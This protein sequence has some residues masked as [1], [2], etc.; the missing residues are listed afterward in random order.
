MVV[1]VDD[2]NRENEGDLVCAAELVTPE[3]I[4]FMASR[5]RGL[6]CVAITDEHANRL[7][8]PPQAPE[9]TSQ[10]GTA[11]TISVDARRG[12]STGISAGDRAHKVQT[13]M[14][15]ERKSVV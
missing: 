13:M 2:E 3:A 9:N 1:L 6:I 10:F 14:R 12:V 8:L 4:N 15:E 11:F 5:A 7:A